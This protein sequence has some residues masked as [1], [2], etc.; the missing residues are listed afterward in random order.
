MSDQRIFTRRNDRRKLIVRT[1]APPLAVT[2]VLVGIGLFVLYAEFVA[3]FSPYEMHS[4]QVVPTVV[5][6][7]DE[8]AVAATR[9][10]E[11]GVGV[12]EAG[13]VSGWVEAGAYESGT[14][15]VYQEVDASVD[16]E[17]YG[18]TTTES[19]VR[20]VAPEIAG[21]YRL[22]SEYEFDGEVFGFYP[23]TQHLTAL[24]DDTIRVLD[25]GSEECE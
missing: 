14:Y 22:Y 23:K 9:T 17:E 5:C 25:P 19:S 21:H 12:Q 3:D 8:V 18:R 1:L 10:L 15:T 11:E 20:R 7:T 4:Y 24:S 13:V 16:I 2:T 6:P